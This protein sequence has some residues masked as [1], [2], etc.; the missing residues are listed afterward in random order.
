MIRKPVTSASLGP[1]L[2]VICDDGSVWEFDPGGTWVER[3]PIPGTSSDVRADVALRL[4]AE[5]RDQEQR[6]AP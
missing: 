3:Q 4:A 5:R 1:M 2:L 6:E